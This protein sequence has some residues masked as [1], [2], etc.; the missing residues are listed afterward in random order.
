MRAHAGRNEPLRKMADD[1]YRAWPA[2]QDNALLRLAR[3]RMLG[4]GV[5][6]GARSAAAQQGLL[7]VV[8]DFCDRSNAICADC[9]F[10]ALVRGFVALEPQ[11]GR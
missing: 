7:Q 5:S 2:A 6:A 3:R 8:H 10:P 9:Q 1:R 11:L 4:R